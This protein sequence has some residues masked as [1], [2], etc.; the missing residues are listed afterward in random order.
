MGDG[1]EAINDG[2]FSATLIR[3]V[4]IPRSVARLQN[5]A[6]K[7]CPRLESATV[8]S[9]NL[10]YSLGAGLFWNCT[11]LKKVSLAEGI[12]ETGGLTFA[13]CGS[14]ES[15]TLPSTL[16]ALSFND[17][18][19]C[20]AL[21]S[22][23]L[24]SYLLKQDM[25]DK[26]R[27]K[28]YSP[29]AALKDEFLGL[30]LPECNKV[31]VIL[32]PDDGNDWDM[33]FDNRVRTETSAAFGNGEGREVGSPNPLD[34]GPENS[35]PNALAA[36]NSAPAPETSSHAAPPMALGTA[37]PDLD[38]INSSGASKKATDGPAQ[39]KMKVFEIVKDAVA[40]NPLLSL[41][42]GAII[43]AV[44]LLGGIGRY[45]RYVRNQ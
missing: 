16:Q 21:K 28:D 5:Y 40:E 6:F 4:D 29:F 42:A 24:Q 23:G 17:F 14:L 19:G 45:R 20:T 10:D 41:A 39:N 1:I 44:L 3:T 31:V 13:G 8:E 37:A 30:D 18:S 11:N 38:S 43:L 25:R 34:P 12:K 36:S 27:A 9:G 2:A 15:I 35:S 7:D 26:P 22:I 33:L 32:H